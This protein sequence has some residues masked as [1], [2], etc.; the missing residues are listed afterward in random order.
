MPESC[1]VVFGL[2]DDKEKQPLKGREDA[3]VIRTELNAEERISELKG[4]GSWIDAWPGVRSSAGRLFRRG[5][6]HRAIEGR[7]GKG[8]EANGGH[9]IADRLMPNAKKDDSAYQSSPE[10]PSET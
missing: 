8:S 7:D 3:K 6:G 10:N 1:E 2:N 9:Q 5:R 4:W